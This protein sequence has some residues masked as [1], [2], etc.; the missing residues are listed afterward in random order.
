VKVKSALRHS[1]IHARFY[2]ILLAGLLG[3][4]AFVPHVAIGFF[5]GLAAI[6]LAMECINIVHITRKARKN[7]DYLEE[8]IQ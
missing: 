4:F 1:K 8:K 7:P 6:G 3:L 2:G 5:A